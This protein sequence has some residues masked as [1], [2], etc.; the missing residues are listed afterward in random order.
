MTVAF[1][2][3]RGAYSELAARLLLPDAAPTGLITF[4]QV[5]DAVASGKVSRG[6]VPL[7]NSRSGSLTEVVDL[8]IERAGADVTVVAEHWLRMDQN[9]LALPGTRLEDVT[10]VRSHAQAFL[11]SAEFLKTHLPTALRVP[12]SD[13]AG[14]ARQIASEQLDGVAALA[15]S[16][17]A[18][19]Y[20]LEV[21]AAG[22]EGERSSFTRF[23]LLAPAGTR[24]DNANR[25]TLVIAPSEQAPNALFRA[26]TTFVG[27]RLTLYRVEP[28]PRDGRPGR[29]TYLVDIEGDAHAQTVAAAVE[30]AR[31]FC[32]RLVVAGSYKMAPV[33]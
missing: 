27:R 25:S 2:G 19:L 7:E 14:A 31:A 30:D 9:L 22:A 4:G 6:V 28:R 20:G 21:I 10:Q 16:A 1:Q 12:T 8:L 5:F 18:E 23:L 32:D 26:L 17:A 3:E 29:Y 33:S 11:Q 24:A 13:T 15:S